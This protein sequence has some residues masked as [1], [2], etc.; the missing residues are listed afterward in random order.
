M[1][2]ILCLVAVALNV[3]LT[4]FSTNVIVTHGDGT[5]TSIVKTDPIITTSMSVADMFRAGQ[6][7]CKIV[8]S[9]QISGFYAR[10]GVPTLLAAIAG[11]LVPVVLAMAALYLLLVMLPNWL[12]QSVA[13]VFVLIGAAVLLMIGVGVYRAIFSENVSLAA[14][15]RDRDGSFTLFVGE[16]AILA[17]GLGLRLLWT[18]RT[19]T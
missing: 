10:K 15:M 11:I 6:R 1:T 16:A 2:I 4:Q 12:R 17:E 8:A 13:V 7:P 9:A 14:L 3:G 18:A 19:A 5:V